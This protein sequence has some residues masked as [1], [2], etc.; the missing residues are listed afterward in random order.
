MCRGSCNTVGVRGMKKAKNIL[1]KKTLNLAVKEKDRANDPKVVLPFAVIAAVL[2]VIFGKMAVADR[3]SAASSVYSEVSYINQRTQELRKE[4]EQYDDVRKQYDHY[5]Y[6]AYSKDELALQNV[7][8]IFS[9]IDSKLLPNSQINSLVFNSNVLN[10]VINNVTLQDVSLIV[11]DLYKS[12]IVDTVTVSTA[13]TN[14]NKKLA[15]GQDV[16]A[17]VTVNLKPKNSGGDK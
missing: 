1:L 11:S 13:I 7:G 4:N 8:D 3:L 6:S 10:V 2:I 15:Q 9:L 5:T 17:T 16:T 14:E 12:P